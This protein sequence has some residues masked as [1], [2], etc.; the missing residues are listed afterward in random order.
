MIVEPS[1]PSGTTP[2]GRPE[3]RRVT[4]VGTTQFGPNDWLAP[5]A[6][7]ALEGHRRD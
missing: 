5:D 7:F 1:I 6:D 3:A 2:S 4:C